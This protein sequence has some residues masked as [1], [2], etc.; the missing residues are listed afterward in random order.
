MAE[1]LY[2]SSKPRRSDFTGAAN[3][4]YELDDFVEFAIKTIRANNVSA[5]SS[6]DANGHFIHIHAP[7]IYENLQGEPTKI[8]GNA[9]DVQGEFCMVKIKIEDLKFFPIMGVNLPFESEVATLL[10]TE[11]LDGTP[12]EGEDGVYI[13]SLNKWIVFCHEMKLPQ[14]DVRIVEDSNFTLGQLR[15]AGFFSAKFCEAFQTHNS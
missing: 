2:S 11:Q 1:V 9:S 8:V 12:L 10:T 15:V 14:E 3:Q 4:V 5:I 13:G 6:V 7:S